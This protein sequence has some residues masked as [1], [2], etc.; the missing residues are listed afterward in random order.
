MKNKSSL[1]VI[2][3]MIEEKN[4][5]LSKLFRKEIHMKKSLKSRKNEEKKT[6]DPTMMQTYCIHSENKTRL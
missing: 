5:N 6:L 1:R 2:W 3:N 4:E